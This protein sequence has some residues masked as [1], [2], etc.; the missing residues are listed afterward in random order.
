MDTNPKQLSAKVEES[1]DE[2]TNEIINQDPEIAVEEK[3]PREE[4]SP[5]PYRYVEPEF[6]NE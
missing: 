4:D 6:Y 1:P 2:A 3:K 5:L